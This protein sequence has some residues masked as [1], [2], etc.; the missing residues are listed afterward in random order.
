MLTVHAVYNALNISQ[1]PAVDT[2]DL[3]TSCS[4]N[5]DPSQT[6]KLNAAARLMTRLGPRDH[7]TPTMKDRHWLPIEQRIVFRLCLLMHQVHT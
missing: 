6:V 2:V 3:L 1:V 5:G 4:C 7:V